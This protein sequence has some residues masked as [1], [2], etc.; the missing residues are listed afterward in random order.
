MT[1]LEYLRGIAIGAEPTGSR[2]ICDPPVMDTD[3]DYVVWVGNTTKDRLE[4]DGFVCTTL[5]SDGDYDDMQDFVT[6]RR[7]KI[8]LITTE[9]GTFYGY[10]NAATSLAKRLK[11]NR[12]EDR[13][14]LF[15]AILY[16]NYPD[17]AP[18]SSV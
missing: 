5:C 8:N 11:L 3:E 13:I 15:Q 4:A 6:Y 18:S 7:G 10:F 9:S 17:D 1:T 2:V 16:E 14:T 12:K